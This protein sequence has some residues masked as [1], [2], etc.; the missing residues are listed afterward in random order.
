MSKKV[1]RDEQGRIIFGTTL[2]KAFRDASACPKQLLEYYLLGNAS[3]EQTE[4]MLKGNV[5]EYLCLGATAQDGEVPDLPRLKTVDKTDPTGFKKSSDH[6]RIEMQAKLF[7]MVLTN[8]KITITEKQKQLTYIMNDDFVI[9]TKADIFGSLMDDQY[10]FVEEAYIDLKL[11]KDLNNAFGDYQWHD[12]ELRDHTQAFLTCAVHY[13]MTGR[14]PKFYYLVF[15]YK[16]ECEHELIEKK[17]TLNDLHEFFETIRT[18]IERIGEYH[19]ANWPT[20]PN[21]NN[22]ES[23]LLKLTCPAIPARKPIKRI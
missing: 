23:C 22:C 4:A 13:K 1:Y 14:V 16:E 20:N 17:V 7:P 2:I 18:V 9:A 15:D 6:K 3:P 10:G 5:F 21:W 8:H 11:T 19:A 12:P